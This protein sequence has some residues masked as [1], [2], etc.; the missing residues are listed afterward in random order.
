MSEETIWTDPTDYEIVS[1]EERPIR[2]NLKA[3]CPNCGAD[4]A[5][6]ITTQTPS[7]ATHL[8]YK[9]GNC[10]EDQFEGIEEIRWANTDPTPNKGSVEVTLEED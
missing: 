3:V 10:K 7:V 8:E 6:E 4:N 9:C 2:I 1:S 5:H